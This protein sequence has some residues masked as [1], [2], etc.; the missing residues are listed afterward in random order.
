MLSE[1]AA[2]RPS[3]A[4]PSLSGRHRGKQPRMTPGLGHELLS[5]EGDLNIPHV[6]A[7]A[8]SSTVPSPPVETFFKSPLEQS[9]SA[10]PKCCNGMAAPTLCR[11]SSRNA[12]I[13]TTDITKDLVYTNMLWGGKKT[14]NQEFFLIWGSDAV[15]QTNDIGHTANSICRELVHRV[16]RASVQAR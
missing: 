7:A 9:Q 5:L 2:P 6:T 12:G 8:G 1:L 4:R 11:R 13:S 14:P 16:R 10:S 15:M 3:M